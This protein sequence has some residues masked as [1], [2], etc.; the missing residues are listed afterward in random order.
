VIGLLLAVYPAGWR[1]RYGEEFRAVLESRP[2]GPFDV[3][4][5]LLGAID[6]RVTPRHHGASGRLDGGHVVLLRMGGMG[7]VLG[8]ILYFVGI[9]GASGLAGSD[10]PWLAIAA[11]GT[12]GLLAALVGLSAF[13]A[14]RNPKLAWA[15]FAIPAVGALVS[16]VGMAGMT[17]A[18]DSD[19]PFIGSMTPWSIWFVGFLTNLLGSI[20]FGIATVRATVLSRRAA[21][22]LAWSAT[23]VLIAG[24]GGAS[25]NGSPAEAALI[26]GVFGAFSISWVLLGVSALRRGPIVAIRPAPDG[27]GA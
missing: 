2:L 16:V 18:G 23:A 4:D 9:A 3:A 14:Y 19:S 21:Q 1:R 25:S 20:L 8:G 17:L 13:Q 15:A 6:A 11:V 27:A 12:L 24:F 22:A 5:V 26:V 10:A 7:A